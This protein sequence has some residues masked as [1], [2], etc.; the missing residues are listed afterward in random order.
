MLWAQAAGARNSSLWL[1]KHHKCYQKHDY[2]APRQP[3]KS[4]IPEDLPQGH[5]IY[6]HRSCLS[7]PVCTLK[8][9]AD[10]LKK[11]KGC[12]HACT[13]LSIN[14]GSYIQMDLLDLTLIR[15]SPE[16][17]YAC[18]KGTTRSLRVR[19]RC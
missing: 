7:F 2:V 3:C 4:G 13:R 9:S 19:L 14:N 8:R 16:D 10:I 11:N 17:K 12:L 5:G 1:N 6:S 18:S 15:L